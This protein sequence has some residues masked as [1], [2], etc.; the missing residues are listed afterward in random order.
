MA[1]QIAI[2]K[3]QSDIDKTI[4]ILHRAVGIGNRDDQ[5]SV[6]TTLSRTYSEQQ[7]YQSALLYLDKALELLPHQSAFRQYLSER[8]VLILKAIEAKTQQDQR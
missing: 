4:E 6:Y 1:A 7:D 8:R 2:Y 5:V 3:D